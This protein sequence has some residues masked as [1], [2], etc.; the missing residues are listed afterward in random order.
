MGTLILYLI[1][2]SVRNSSAEN[3]KAIFVHH[4]SYDLKPY[5]RVQNLKDISEAEQH[6]KDY[7]IVLIKI[8]PYKLLILN[9]VRRSSRKCSNGSDRVSTRC[10][11]FLTT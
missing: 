4:I 5:S 7:L 6:N 1:Y 3:S 10:K 8:L 2:V 11:R 9:T